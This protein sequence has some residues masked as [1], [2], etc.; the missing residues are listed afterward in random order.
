MNNATMRKHCHWK[1]YLRVPFASS[2]LKTLSPDNNFV[3]SLR[4]VSIKRHIVMHVCQGDVAG[5]LLF[6][7]E[8]PTWQGL[9]YSRLCMIF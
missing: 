2:P 1:L 3:F 9:N 4:F 5:S 8:T 7:L 6:T